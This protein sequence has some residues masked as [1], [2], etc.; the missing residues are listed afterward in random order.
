MCTVTVPAVHCNADYYLV[1]GATAKVYD[2]YSWPFIHFADLIRGTAGW[3]GGD[4]GRALEP[5]GRRQER[6]LPV[7]SQC[8]PLPAEDGRRRRPPAGPALNP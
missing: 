6:P 1:G 2:T 5:L 8:W 7:A 4:R 3:T